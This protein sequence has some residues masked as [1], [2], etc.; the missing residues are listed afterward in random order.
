MPG[1]LTANGAASGASIR[2]QGPS[3][4]LLAGE[5]ITVAVHISG[6]ADL[7]AVQLA[8]TF[9]PG[10]VQIL[11]SD[12][13]I[14]GVQ[15]REGSCPAPDFAVSNEADNSNG[16]IEYALTQLSP[17]A[18]VSGSCAVAAIRLRLLKPGLTSIQLGEAILSDAD[19]R[20]LA[21]DSTDLTLAVKAEQ[22]TFLPLLSQG[23]AD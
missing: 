13:E 9:A 12:P 6:A 15:I 10:D 5:E 17:R 23:D 21:F 22:F 14:E 20:S 16:T 2:L 3:E 19:G 8:L 4:Q 1:R 11:D 7:Y 18:P